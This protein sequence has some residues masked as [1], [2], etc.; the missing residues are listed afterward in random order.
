VVVT[1][2]SV[3]IWEKNVSYLQAAAL[4]SEASHAFQRRE[5]RAS[6]ELM[7]RAIALAPDVPSYYLSRARLMD[8]FATRDASDEVEIAAEQYK[9]DKQASNVNP[10]SHVAKLATAQSAL[11]LG[12]LGQADKGA[13][14]VQL[15]KELTR[16]LP[17]F[18][19]LYN[20]LA[21]AQLILGQPQEALATLDAYL[22]FVQGRAEPKWDAYYLRGVAHQALGQPEEAIAFLEK[23]LETRPNGRY[24]APAHNRL[25]DLYAELGQQ[26]KRGEHAAIYEE[27]RNQGY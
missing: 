17:G 8:A 22:Y 19:E 5:L 2:G 7:D 10:F 15:Y 11:K 26:E 9:L 23:F 4:G 18:E 16:M 14:A 27:L 3:L 25:A 20:D 24:T 6:L 1:M 13:E 21:S 12:Q